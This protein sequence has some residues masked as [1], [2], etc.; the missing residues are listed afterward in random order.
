MY[1]SGTSLTSR[2]SA[3]VMTSGMIGPAVCLKY[4]ASPRPPV[5][6]LSL[7]AVRRQSG[8]LQSLFKVPFLFPHHVAKSWRAGAQ[9]IVHSLH[10][11]RLDRLL[12]RQLG[13]PEEPHSDLRPVVKRHLRRDLRDRDR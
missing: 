9:G 7:A 1:P 8:R 3:W 6:A 10:H 5:I 2:F 13:M 12:A 11:S 4:L